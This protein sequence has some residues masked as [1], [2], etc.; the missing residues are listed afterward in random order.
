MA[1]KDFEEE[2]QNRVASGG[3]TEGPDAD[4]YRRVFNAIE[5]E[6]AYNVSD[7]FARKVI[8]QIDARQSTSLS[9]DYIWFGI[10]IIF[11]IASFLVTLTFVDFHIDLGFLSL[12]ADYKGLAIFGIA[13]ILGLNWLDKKLLLGKRVQE[14]Y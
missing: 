4:A 7:D 5:K 12:M 9:K 13:F 6:P 3:S 2:L 11:L 14:N 1:M 8:S 10:G